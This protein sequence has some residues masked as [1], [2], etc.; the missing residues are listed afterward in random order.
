MALAP[1]GPGSSRRRRWRERANRAR[2]AGE[3]HIRGQR[4]ISGPR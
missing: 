4:R 3:V 1:T 2:R